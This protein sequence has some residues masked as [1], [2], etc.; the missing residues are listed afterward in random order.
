[1][2]H[3]WQLTR[4]LECLSLPDREAEFSAGIENDLS[5]ESIWLGE[6]F[7]EMKNACREEIVINEE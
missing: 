5:I 3:E 7:P 4:V 6:G 2:V 1:M